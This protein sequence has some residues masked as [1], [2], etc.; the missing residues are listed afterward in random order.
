[1]IVPSIPV[2]N[3][4]QLLIANAV[5][6]KF[7]PYAPASADTGGETW[8]DGS[9]I[10]Y[11]PDAITWR[12][13]WDTHIR[14]EAIGNVGNV[15]NLNPPPAVN[16]KK[17][18][19]LALFAGP[20]RGVGGYRAVGGFKLGQEAVIRLAPV[21]INNPA[22]AIALP[23]PWTFLVIERSNLTVTIQIFQNGKWAALTKLTPKPEEK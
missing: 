7:E 9:G 2:A 15:G 18:V 8:F 10:Y 23:R 11:C 5:A 4:A 14:N 1:M 16:F 17:N 13:V 22:N 12:K 3:F 21:P 20:T 19:V 6:A